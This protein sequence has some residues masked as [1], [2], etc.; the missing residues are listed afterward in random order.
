MGLERLVGCHRIQR[1]PASEKRGRRHSSEVVVL[2]VPDAAAST[3]G[4]DL[5]DVRIDTFRASGP[6]GQNVN[7]VSSAVR[8]THLPTGVVVTATEDRSQHVNRKMAWQR[9]AAELAR[10]SR[11]SDA[12]T[13]ARARSGVAGTARSWTWCGWR[14]EV[15]SG[16]GKARMSTV[17]GGWLGPLL[18]VSGD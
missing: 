12:D 17:L 7:K 15:K 16:C 4:A 18:G 10:R 9:L 3:I 11:E 13:M 14:D 6:G 5:K 8:I 1:V 2:L